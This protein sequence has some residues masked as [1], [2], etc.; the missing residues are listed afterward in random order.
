MKV[1]I[2]PTPE[3]GAR[4]V[5]DRIEGLVRYKPNSVLGLA[6]GSSPISLYKE[7]VERSYSINWAKVTTI[8]LDNYCGLADDHPQSYR[9][10][11]NAN[12]F[13]HILIHKDCQTFVPNGM[14]DEEDIEA[15]CC[16]YM[17]R[18]I[19]RGGIDLQILGIGTNAHIAFNEPGSAFDSRTR[20]VELDEATREVNKR[21]FGGDITKVPTHA[22]TMGIGT[23][24]EAREIYLLAWGEG[25]AEAV[26]KSVEGPVTTQV[27]ASV[28]QLHQNAAFVVDD[29]A[30]L[31]LKFKDRYARVLDF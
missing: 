19:E 14:G 18:I 17:S 7:L 23:I 26:A 21:F 2:V 30:V 10:E 6:T 8:N 13:D 15:E 29:A 16:N 4:I 12:L 24:M 28:L 25:K 5:A 27:P 20:R 3:I 22:L 11:M 31:A 1:M 9:A